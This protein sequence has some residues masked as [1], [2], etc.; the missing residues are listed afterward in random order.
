M[1]SKRMRGDMITLH[2]G[3]NGI[4]DTVIEEIKLVLKK[5][6]I[7]RLKFLKTFM[8]EE[9]K[10]RSKKEIYQGIAEQANAKIEKAVGFTVILKK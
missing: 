10:K 6:R 4:T 3:K 2:V 7:V 8:E 1:P 9:K 5:Y